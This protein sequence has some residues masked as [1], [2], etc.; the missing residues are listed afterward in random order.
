MTTINQY[1][2][3]Q[4]SMLKRQ[5]IDFGFNP[6]LGLILIFTAFTGLSFYLFNQLAYANY[7]YVLIALSVVFKYSESN[8]NDFLKFN[9]SKKTYFTIRILENVITVVPFLIF[10]CFRQ[11]FYPL[12]FLVLFSTSITLIN[13]QKQSSLTIPTPFYKK[14]FEFIVGFRNCIILFLL[15]YFLTAIAVAYNNF[16]V[17]LFALMLVFL[18][19]LSF[20]TQTENDFYVWIYKLNAKAFVLHKIKT[21]ILFSTLICLPITLVLLFFFQTNIRAIIG[22]QTLGYCYLLTIILAK[23]SCYPQKMSLPQSLLLAVGVTM[24]PILLVLIPF[25]YFKSQQQLKEIL[26]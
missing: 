16:N 17:G 7:C 15:A 23:Y 6:I 10:L 9:F 3:L 26:E 22:F 20:Y 18:V 5:L 24:P 14:P 12:L 11:E 21:A 8:R 4:F 19:C 1:F 25:F 2:R 13:I